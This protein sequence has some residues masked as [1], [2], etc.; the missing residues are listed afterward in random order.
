MGFCGILRQS[1]AVD[2]LI[3]PF[4]DSTDGDTEET[5]LTIAQA[6]VRLSKN[7]QTAAQKNDNTTC[8]HDAD[9]FYNC[10]LDATDTNTVGQLTLYVHVAGAL[11]V[12]HDFQIVEEAVYDISFEAS[13]TG[14][15]PVA[16]IASNA[17]TA[18]ALATDA[19]GEIADAVWDED[20]TG[21]Q[22]QGTFGQ[23]IGDPGADTDTIY[24]LANT[25]SAALPSAAAG[26]SGGLII[27]G[28]N[29]GTVTLAAL[30]VTGNVALQAGVTI[31]QS[32]TNGHGLSIAG[33]GTGHGA[34][35]TSGSGVTGNGVRVE[36][37]STSGDGF[38][39]IG[40][41]AVGI[42]IAGSSPTG[43]GFYAA[44]GAGGAYLE[45]TATGDGIEIKGLG[46]GGRGV[47]VTTGDGNAVELA[48]AGTARH[49]ILATGASLGTSDGIKAVAGAAGGV[50][51]RGDLT[52]N[53]TGTITE[54][55]TAGVQA[56]WDF[57]TSALTAVG[58]IGK[59]LVDSINATI[60]SRASQTSVDDLP[61]NA[62]LTTALASADD[63]TLAAIAALN[64]LAAGAAMTLTTA[65]RNAI[66]DAMFARS[67]GTEAVSAQ[68]AV[69][70]FAQAVFEMLSSLG[71]FSIAGT[72]ITC[73]KRDGTTSLFTSTLDDATTPTART[74]AT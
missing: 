10:E 18:S 1:T 24:A 29:A 62:E 56:I 65:E 73:K 26:A 19:A 32:T 6:D 49:A 63:A 61:T 16:S 11:A 44:G 41:G 39:A 9:G 74:R 69:P 42:G 38:R 23:A 59:L 22:T 43:F 20:A 13:A 17:I 4:V 48:P 54:L 3:G 45:A 40:K 51:I 7:G 31:T 28:S 25:M 50:P 5:G 60:S 58:S 57:L 12:R 30:T 68:G 55:S 67:L 33:N 2:V 14:A 53:I 66:A 35:I 71:E 37:L 34:Y 46:T 8:A 21:H 47:Y 72:T 27:N 70:T 52:G 36:A 15:V 64:N